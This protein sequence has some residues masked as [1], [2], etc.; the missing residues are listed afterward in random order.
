ME[1]LIVVIGALIVVMETL[2]VVIGALIVVT[3]ALIVVGTAGIAVTAFWI[4]VMEA[5]IAVTAAWTVVWSAAMVVT[6]WAILVR[7]AES[8]QRA[9]GIAVKRLIDEFFMVM[10]NARHRPPRNLMDPHNPHYG[11]PGAIYGQ[12]YYSAG[13]ANPQPQPRTHMAEVKI[14]LARMNADD[15][16]KELKQKTALAA[17]TAP[18]TPPIANMGDAVT[19]LNTKL[20]ALETAN[21]AYKTLKAQTAAAKTTRDDA[22]DEARTEGGLF[23]KKA[24]SESKGDAGQL[25]SIGF[26]VTGTTTPAPA[27]PVPQLQNFIITAGD[28]DGSLDFSVDPPSGVKV[29][30]YLWQYTAGDPINGPWTSATPT[31][32]SSTTVSG[33]TSGQRIWG[34]GAGVGTKGQGPWS[35]PFTKIVP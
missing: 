24:E 10:H 11:E 25:Q 7:E 19:S 27:G 8:V 23:I 15:L 16:L 4:V 12:V 26:Q 34:R 14:N 18:A 9:G 35:D 22:L 32:A 30:T 13:P 33:L 28:N 2:I 3:E 1:T 31:T 20:S 5:G 6:A 17:P 21:N 29:K